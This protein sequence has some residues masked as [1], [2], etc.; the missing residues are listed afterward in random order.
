[1]VRELKK[2]VAQPEQIVTWIAGD[3]AMLAEHERRVRVHV[4]VRVGMSRNL[5]LLKKVP[6]SERRKEI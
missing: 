2:Q 5:G 4:E 6:V 3:A 1:M